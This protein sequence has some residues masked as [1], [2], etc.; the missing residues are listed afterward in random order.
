MCGELE[1]LCE[2]E[3]HKYSPVQCSGDL[4][5]SA[6]SEMAEEDL[7]ESASVW[8]WL[9]IGSK[10]PDQCM[11]SSRIETTIEFQPEAD[12]CQ[13]VGEEGE[14]CVLKAAVVLSNPW[15]LEA[16]SLA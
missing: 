16:S 5:R 9:F 2:V 14:H 15:N 8:H 12:R 3:D 11:Y 10:H 1:R 6:D 4:G 7:S 13:Y